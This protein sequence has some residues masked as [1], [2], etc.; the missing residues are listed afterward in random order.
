[1]S[2][3]PTV[4]FANLPY[5]TSEADPKTGT[6]SLRQGV[7]AGSRWPFTR[8]APFAPDKFQ[9]GHYLPYPMFMGSAAAWVQRALPDATV[10]FRDSVARGESYKTFDEFWQDTAPSHVILEVG[11]S[12]IEH[13]MQFVRAMRRSNPAVRIALAG[14]PV[15]EIAKT[16]EG[17]L[18]D[19]FLTG[20]Y[21]KPSVDFVNGASG[22]LPFTLL[23]KEE[24]KTAPFP[25][26]DE[27]V[28]WH[29]TDANPKG[30]RFPELTLWGS[31]GCYHIC[32]FCAW[33]ATM[34]GDDPEGKGGRP[35]RFYDP[36]WLESFIEHRISLAAKSG[37]PLQTVR[38]DDD[39]GNLKDRHTLAI[40]EVMQRIRLPWSMMCR[41]DT[42]SPATWKAMKYAGCF[43][44]KLG[45]ESGSQR[46]IDEVIHKKL[47]LKKAKE[48]AMWL[49]KEVG[50]SVHG[51]FTINLPGETVEERLQTIAFIRELHRDGA[52]DSHQL[53]GTAEIPGTPLAN[54]AHTDPSYVPSA[55][56]QLKLERMNRTS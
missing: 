33:P 19:A 47:D 4:L 48:T 8:E 14:P 28:W 46:V 2:S 27:S 35:V 43:G 53:S 38:F 39:S 18:V 12:S 21:E 24:L 6:L 22:V 44:V 11:A 15:R 23:T 55:D 5:W 31:R 29:Y 37:R 36:K 45:F 20:E 7:R 17:G 25:M 16:M 42:S 9:F 30:A 1:M 51:T 40:C 41:A 10:I 32:S 52:L 50:M 54:A 13:D 26:F 34:T 49:R 3:A 56:G